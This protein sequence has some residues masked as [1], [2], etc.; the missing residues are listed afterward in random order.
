MCS[1][2]LAV[3]GARLPNNP[4]SRRPPWLPIA[5]FA[6]ATETQMPNYFSD[7]QMLIYLSCNFYNVMLFFLY[8]ASPVK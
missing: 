5:R 6:Q 1:L 8:R 7:A 2:H 4:A 3:R